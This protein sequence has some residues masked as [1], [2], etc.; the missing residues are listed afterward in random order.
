MAKYHINGN[1]E[2]KQCRANK[3]PCKFQHFDSMEEAEKNA[4]EQMSQRYG[5]SQGM[6]RAP[7]R[8]NGLQR[9]ARSG[10][11]VE[12]VSSV[13]THDFSSEHPE[14]SSVDI[15]EEKPSA[16]MLRDIRSGKLS[17]SSL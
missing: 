16:E 7:R 6:R 2:A 1:G 5:G 4:Q 3:R 10:V 15:V 8:D 9:L 14:E 12:T 17:F 13:S 11:A